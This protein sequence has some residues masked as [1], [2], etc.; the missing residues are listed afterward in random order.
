MQKSSKELFDKLSD[1]NYTESTRYRFKKEES[2]YL[3]GRLC[4][5]DWISELCFHFQER[6]K[7]LSKEF[8]QII[9]D[10]KRSFCCSK[11]VTIKMAYLIL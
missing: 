10:K 2:K 7:N 1:E 4:F 3:K 9:A 8:E 5:Y 11:R 6:E